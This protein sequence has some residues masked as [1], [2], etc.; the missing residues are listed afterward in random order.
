[1]EKTEPKALEI[2]DVHVLIEMHGEDPKVK[3]VTPRKLE[4]HHLKDEVRWIFDGLPANWWIRVD[5]GSDGPVDG[6]PELTRKPFKKKLQS[7]PGDSELSSGATDDDSVGDPGKKWKK[8]WSYKLVP[9]NGK[10]SGIGLDPWVIVTK[11]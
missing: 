4:I 11:P 9:V 8:S 3:S 5:P 6:L 2:K 10:E 7:K 1:M